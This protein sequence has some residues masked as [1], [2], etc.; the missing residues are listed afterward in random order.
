MITAEQTIKLISNTRRTA[1]NLL[2]AVLFATFTLSMF[3]ANCT[4]AIKI[5]NDFI[6]QQQHK[7]VDLLRIQIPTHTLKYLEAEMGV[8]EEMVHLGQMVLRDLEGKE[9]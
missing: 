1:F 2:A 6:M 3:L 8:M 5:N 9:D 4:H 7:L